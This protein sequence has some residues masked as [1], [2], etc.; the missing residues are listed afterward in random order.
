MEPSIHRKKLALLAYPVY[1]ELLA[2]VIA[3]IVD[4]IWVARL[5]E[6]AVA[7]VAVA[8]NFENVLLGIILMVSSGSTVLISVYLGK[9]DIQGVKNV[10]KGSWILWGILAPV[11]AVSGFFLRE[12]IASLFIDKNDGQTLKLAVDFFQISFPGVLVFFAQNISDSFFKGDSNTRFPMK[13]AIVANICILVLDPLF[14]YGLLG[15]PRLGVQGAAIATLLG[16]MITLAI[17]LF[18]L[19]RSRLIQMSR[20]VHTTGKAF[21]TINQILNFGLPMSGDFI[22]RMVGNMILIGLIG[23]FGVANLAGYGIGSKILVFVTMSFYAI[24][25]ASSIYTARCIGT[26]HKNEIHSIGRQSLFLGFCLAAFAS[27]ILA[28]F[29]TQLISLFIADS[30]VIAAGTLYLHYMCIYL[31]AL[32]CVISLGGVFQGAGKSRLLL[33]VTIIGISIQIIIA[34]GLS[35]FSSLHVAGIWIAIIVGTLIQAIAVIFLFSSRAS[36]QGFIVDPA[37]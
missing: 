33:Y 34:Y 19:G 20:A 4:T 23:S 6:H 35:F 24:R 12:P 30:S 17:S 22:L 32:T 18:Y 31:L 1:F 15:V 13:M 27:A 14:I 26:G 9:K 21:A 5:G 7:A 3:G 2:G 36:F 28:L 11:I 8:T 10:V 16:R 37:H 29:A 25:Q